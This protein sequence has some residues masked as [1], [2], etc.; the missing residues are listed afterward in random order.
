MYKI[1]VGY[2]NWSDK[3]NGKSAGFKYLEDTPEYGAIFKSYKLYFIPKNLD[4]L[5]DTEK[6]K[7]SKN[8]LIGIKDDGSIVTIASNIIPANNYDE[9]IF[10]NIPNGEYKTVRFEL[11][12]EMMIKHKYD[13]PTQ[14]VFNLEFNISINEETYNKID[15][16]FKIKSNVNNDYRM[17]NRVVLF[18]SVG[19]N[20][21]MATGYVYKIP[22]AS[23]F[24]SGLYLNNSSSAINIIAKDTITAVSGFESQRLLLEPRSFENLKFIILL[25]S[26]VTYGG[27]KSDR[28]TLVI[29]ENYSVINNFKETGLVAYIHDATAPALPATPEA[30]VH[31]SLFYSI[32]STITPSGE[33]ANGTHSVKTML[34]W[35]N[36][37]QDSLNMISGDVQD[38][39]DL[40]NSL[41]TS[42]MIGEVSN[43]FSYTSSSELVVSKQSKLGSDYDNMYSQVT[44][45]DGTSIVDYQIVINNKTSNTQSGYTMIDILP[46]KNDYSIVKDKNGN[47][48][49]RGSTFRATLVGRVDDVRGYTIYYSTDAPK[50]KLED[51]LS[52]TWKSY[53]DI[54]NFSEVTMIKIVMNDDYEIYANVKNKIKYKVNI[55]D[56]KI[57]NDTDLAL[58]S[59]G[60][61]HNNDIN[62]AIECVSNILSFNEYVVSG[63]AYYDDNK[64][65]QYS[66]GDRIINNRKVTLYQTSYNGD[67][68]VA[69]AYTDTNGN[70]KFKDII[71]LRGMYKVVFDLDTDDTIAPMKTSTNVLV[72]NDIDQYASNQFQLD[73][74]S[75]NK[76][77]NAGFYNPIPLKGQVI[78]KYVDE[79]GNEIS[80]SITLVDVV[81][82]AYQ[83][84]KKDISGYTLTKE[85]TNLKGTFT[86][87]VQTVIYTYKKNATTSIPDP[88]KPVIN[89]GRS[90]QDDGYPAGYYWSESAQACVINRV[91]AVPKTSETTNSLYYLALAITSLLGILV[92]RRKVN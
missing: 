10:I 83:T 35:D 81:G 30:T 29:S 52:A 68:K 55:P 69:E 27:S 48:A 74:S 25:P 85:P 88:V 11:D 18:D 38:Q 37:S 4:Q 65:G 53:P 26:G 71:N 6:A 80:S 77:V 84:S 16:F 62:T 20:I 92:I 23:L 57:L 75:L 49:K 91:Y 39:Y 32:T 78:V 50:E 59:V 24:S 56:T 14:N 89:K 64:D 90:C 28:D 58:N 45:V 87:E 47:Y 2:S 33:L 34:V 31:Q 40:N 46:Y 72:G 86:S 42:D 76:I 8:K 43:Q 3:L 36:N 70:Y 79:N 5:T 67:T 12:E 73:T 19:N 13:Y 44:N 63:K 82:T 51:N 22:Y 60:L 54:I 15:D 21:K 17:I 9:A 41:S 7:L 61:I 1:A 66:S